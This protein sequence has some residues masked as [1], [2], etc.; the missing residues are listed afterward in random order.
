MNLLFR[1]KVT[2]CDPVTIRTLIIEMMKCI[3]LFF[4]LE[5]DEQYEINLILH[6]L[7]SNGV[8]HGN[9]KLCTKSLIAIIQKVSDQKI[10]ICIQDEGQGFQYHDVFH[11]QVP[12]E[13]YLLSERGRGLKLVHAMCDSVRI[14]Y[15]GNQVLVCKSIRKKS[16]V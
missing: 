6:E 13:E 5:E 11:D 3:Q 15:K 7:I 10:A 1:K 2:G 14:N 12:S 8:I 9:K 16:M 4:T